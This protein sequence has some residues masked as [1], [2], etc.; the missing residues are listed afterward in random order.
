[1]GFVKKTN[2]KAILCVENMKKLDC[3]KVLTNEEIVDISKIKP[4]S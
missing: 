4:F 2:H 3:N 1:M